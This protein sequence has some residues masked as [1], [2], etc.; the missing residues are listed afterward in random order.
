MQHREAECEARCRAVGERLQAMIVVKDKSAARLSAQDGAIG[1][2]ATALAEKATAVQ[3]VKCVLDR[4]EE[5][6]RRCDRGI[7]AATMEREYIALAQKAIREADPADTIGLASSILSLPSVLHHLLL[8]R[9]VSEAA[10]NPPALAEFLSRPGGLQDLSAFL[11]DRAASLREAIAGSA[12][13]RVASFVDV[14]TA[15][16]ALNLAVER[17]Q[18]HEAALLDAQAAR[19][20]EALVLRTLSADARALAAKSALVSR[21]LMAARERLVQLRTGPLAVLGR[22]AA[23]EAEAV[24]VGERAQRAARELVRRRR[25]SWLPRKLAALRGTSSAESGALHVAVG[26]LPTPGR[27]RSPVLGE[28]C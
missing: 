16:A 22:L 2:R 26:G 24:E 8:P 10:S 18:Q 28:S 12:L 11:A 17:R 21:A 25:C 1:S 27:S 6:M 14:Q 13:E 4:A 15:S 23:E 19:G 20:E 9:C 5:G 3:A 7:G